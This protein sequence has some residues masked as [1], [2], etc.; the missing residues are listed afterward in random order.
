MRLF[1]AVFPGYEVKTELQK[2]QEEIRTKAE[3]G[4]F[5]R[6]ENLHLTLIFLGE[7]PEERLKSLYT[8]IQGIKAS[9]FEVSFNRTGYFS[10]GRNELW[11]AGADPNDPRLPLLNSVHRQL[12]SGLEKEGFYVDKK[13]FKAH[14]TLAREISSSRPIIMNNPQLTVKV[15]H[16]SLVK[17]ERIQGVLTYTEIF[18]RDLKLNPNSC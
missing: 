13:P 4:S 15:D 10:Q 5:T 7:T 6:P 12:V 11:W 8:I 2:L 14:I 16:I 1:I 3:K 9:A 17:S 18:K